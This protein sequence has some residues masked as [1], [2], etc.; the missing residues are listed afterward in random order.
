LVGIEKLQNHYIQDHVQSKYLITLKKDLFYY[1]YV[2]T[3]K[4]ITESKLKTL[5][6]Y[7]CF[8]DRHKKYRSTQ[9]KHDQLLVQPGSN[10]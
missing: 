5:L 2:Y 10:I 9:I 3:Y 4:L 6:V 1:M 7:T 8:S